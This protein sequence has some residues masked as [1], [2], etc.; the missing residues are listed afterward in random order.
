MNICSAKTFLSA[1]NWFSY[2]LF[3]SGVSS[4]LLGRGHYSIDVLLAYFVTT[5]LWWFYHIM[6]TNNNLKHS[7]RNNFLENLCWWHA[8]R[9]V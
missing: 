7:S 2:C 4:L 3:L 6:A 9:S 1:R 5:R 8:A